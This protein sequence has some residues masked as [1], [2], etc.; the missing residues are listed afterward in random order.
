MGRGMTVQHTNKG[1]VKQCG[2]RNE[3]KGTKRMETQLQE[4]KRE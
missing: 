1:N 4:D 3:A 2:K